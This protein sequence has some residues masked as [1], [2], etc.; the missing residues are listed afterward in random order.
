MSDAIGW[1]RWALAAGVLGA[2]VG[3][4]RQGEGRVDAAGG[5]AE[6]ATTP[7]DGFPRASPGEIFGS[8]H[9]DRAATRALWPGETLPKEWSVDLAASDGSPVIEGLGD[10]VQLI[11]A[12]RRGHVESALFELPERRDVERLRLEFT[13]LGAGETAL[14]VATLTERGAEPVRYL[15]RRSASADGTARGGARPVSRG[16]WARSS[17]IDKQR[18]TLDNGVRVDVRGPLDFLAPRARAFLHSG[19]RRIW[20]E[21]QGH[22]E[23]E[24]VRGPGDDEGLVYRTRRVRHVAEDGSAF[25]FMDGS[26]FEYGYP[27]VAGAFSRFQ[28]V[29]LV[30]DSILLFE[31]GEVLE[32]D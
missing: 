2:I 24:L 4:L 8:W 31:N 5:P 17:G 23:A 6:A 26:T 1:S 27:T 12:W 3:G 15:C 28:T 29:M 21:G 22:R 18:L 19:G 9:L 30:A 13:V 10:G 16:F 14:G 11:E 32:K 25:L 20:L 7:T